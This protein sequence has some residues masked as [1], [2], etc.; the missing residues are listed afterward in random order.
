MRALIVANSPSPKDKLLRI[1]HE[2]ADI[3]IGADGGVDILWRKHLHFD[4]LIGDMDSTI[5]ASLEP[6]GLG[7]RWS[8]RAIEF[9]SDKDKTDTELAVEEAIKRGADEI[10]MLGAIGGRIDHTIANIA[11]AARHDVRI[12]YHTNTGPVRLVTPGNPLEM[13]LVPETLVSLTAFA[14]GCGGVTTS[15]LKYALN[16]ETLEVSGRGVENVALG[17]IVVSIE[18]GFLLVSVLSDDP[19][20]IWGNE[21]MAGFDFS[22]V[23][24]SYDGY[25]ESPMGLAVDSIEKD[26]V[27]KFLVDA[28]GYQ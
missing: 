6:H 27:A 7:F 18:K 8:D 21:T 11:L 2:G 23:A 15:G 17:E 13:T 9:P 3:V 22:A 1:A 12:L 20:L 26:A 25:Y 14:G 10:L 24:E 4:L 28:K 5:L 16:D 19:A